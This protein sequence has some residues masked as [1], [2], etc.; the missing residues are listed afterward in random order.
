MGVGITV[1]DI[2]KRY[3]ATLSKVAAGIGG[4]HRNVTHVGIM[5]AP[6]ILDWVKPGEFLI[7]TGFALENS[8]EAF[9]DLVAGLAKAN[10]AA[11]GLKI[12]RFWDGFPSSV[13]SK[14]N[15]LD[16]PL[17]EIPPTVTLADIADLIQN[18]RK[19]MSNRQYLGGPLSVSE[20]L[21]RLR[22]G[23]LSP[24]QIRF[25]AQQYAIDPWNATM[26]C[27]IELQEQIPIEPIIHQLATVTQGRILHAG[28]TSRNYSCLIS[29][30]VLPT[31]SL[32]T[33]ELTNYAET[34]PIRVFLG[35]LGESIF[36]YATS[37]DTAARAKRVAHF[38]RPYA[39]VVS[40]HDVIVYAV[41]SDRFMVDNLD[42]IVES[43][44]GPILAYDQ[45]NGTEWTTT[46]YE[47][48]RA[49]RNS[50]LA[51]K[52]LN[53]HKNTVMYRI[54]R[55]EREFGL[56]LSLTERLFELFLGFVCHQIRE[57]L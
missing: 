11:L 32:L 23:H 44:I 18:T 52:A 56:D 48:F 16:F 47:F 2:L 12:R 35:T 37:A 3:P 20:F 9:E 26:A 36:D 14:A 25:W 22:S 53:T 38:A 7:T 46:L 8:V 19:E 57:S 28:D 33:E 34:L 39:K 27:Q 55:I 45:I 5:D 50:V 49:G 30:K 13:I 15:T 17:L 4:L 40:F 41:L 10:C 6:D 29:A 31:P 24:A 43:T 21:D 42:T 1:Q 51:A 54:N